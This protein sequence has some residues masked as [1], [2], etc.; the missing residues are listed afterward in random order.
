[1]QRKLLRVLHVGVANRGTWPLRRCTPETGFVPAALVDLNPAALAAAREL[2]GLPTSAC[3]SSMDAA[4]AASDVDCV[5]I[6][7]PTRFHVPLAIKAIAAG[8][9]VL[10]EKGMAPDWAS[11]RELARVVASTP[12]AVAAVAQNYR[13]NGMERTFHRA[14]TDPGYFAYLG[15][16]DLVEYTQ[17]RVRPVV[18]TLNYPFACVWDMSC[19]HFDTLLSWFG[20]MTRMRAFGWRAAWSPYDGVCNTTATI[21]FA[22]GVR[23][24][25]AHTHDAARGVLDIQMHGERGCLSARGTSY[26]D[27][28][29][30]AF[31]ERPGEQFGTR[32]L[33]PVEPEPSDGEGDLLR[34]FHR[35]I[36]EGI[37][38]GISVR[39]NLE[40]MAACEMMV[41]SI[42]LDRP[43]SRAELEAS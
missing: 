28:G 18:G 23:A 10:V 22:S 9:P 6:C 8:K 29:G 24:H 7:T 12:G 37:E 13:Y 34:D 16:V 42:R 32:P 19:H 43:V 36:V 30:M 26:L 41:R 20:P 31:S 33:R 14:V 2:T 11:A 3:F 17:Y 39:N 40:T 27:E 4:L 1:M 21:E 38:P 5:I 15:A 25:Y 35:Y